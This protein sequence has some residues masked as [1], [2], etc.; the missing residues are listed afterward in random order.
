[1]TQVRDAMQ[2]EPRWCFDDEPID[3]VAG[4]MRSSRLQCLP[5]VDRTLRLV[6]ML[7]IDDLPV[8]DEPVGEPRKTAS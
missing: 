3:K 1:M 4:R 2:R 5:V 7:S 6:G 8:F